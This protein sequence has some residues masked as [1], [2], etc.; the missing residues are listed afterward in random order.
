MSIASEITSMGEN[1]KKDYQSIANLG[2]DLTNVDKNIENIAE[3]LDGVYDNLPK[4]EYQEGTEVNLGVTTK[5]K[6]D[7]DNGVVGIGQTEQDGTPTPSTPITINSVTGNQDVVVSGKNEIP[8]PYYDSDVQDRNGVNWS[9]NENGTINASGTANSSSSIFYICNGDDD[10]YLDPGTYKISSNFSGA[11]FSWQVIQ[12]VNGSYGTVYWDNMVLTE[13]TRLRVR[14]IAKP[15]T[16]VSASNCYLMIERG[17]TAT[18]YEPYTTP[19]SYQLSLGDKKLYDECYIV[20]SPDNWKYVDNWYKLTSSVLSGLTIGLSGSGG[21]KFVIVKS[22]FVGVP[23][24]KVG[25]VYCTHLKYN[26]SAWYADGYC[27]IVSPG[28]TLWIQMTQ[29]FESVEAF[30][31]FITTNNMEFVYQTEEPVETPI[32]DTT[33]IQQL[34]NWYY[35][36]SLDGT[37]IIEG[38]G[39]LPMIIKV[40]GLKGE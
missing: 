30:K 12:I 34:N 39:D 11:Q 8:F 17:N 13:R 25:K 19:T 3:L 29:A 32:T 35:G 2:A 28:A 4:T 10:L 18:T 26:P 20:G 23:A 38:N 5:G 33:L 16:E 37:T 15:N 14:V 36:Q 7:Y 31:T 27:G 9:V 1:L 21:K 6:L 40:R 24:P 22:N